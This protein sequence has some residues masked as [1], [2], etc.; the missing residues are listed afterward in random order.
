MIKKDIER[1]Y[2]INENGVITSPGK[3]EGEMYYAV[4]FWGEA[5]DGFSSNDEYLED[6]TVVAV[7][8]LCQEDY[9]NFPELEGNTFLRIWEDEQGF[10]HC[11]TA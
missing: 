2:S 7:F 9:K 5:L 11:M 1:D 10:V 3:F 6:G 8:E 4:S